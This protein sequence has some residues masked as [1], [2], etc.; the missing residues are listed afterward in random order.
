MG[1]SHGRIGL[2]V[3]AVLAGMGLLAVIGLFAL[4]APTASAQAS[5]SCPHEATITS[6]QT[7]VQHAADAGFIDNQSVANSLLAKL[8]AAQ[9]ALTRGQPAVAVNLVQEFSLEVRAQ[10]G[11]HIEA[12]HADHMLMHAEMVIAALE[13]S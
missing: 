11:I 3:S 2:V 10:R 9:A 12:E 6:L 8:D 1:R 5:D 13:G 4:R 7:C